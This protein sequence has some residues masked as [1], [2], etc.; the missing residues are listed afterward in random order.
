VA[1]AWYFMNAGYGTG[2]GET[3]ELAETGTNFS[4]IGYR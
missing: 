4:A 2:N 3:A 1:K